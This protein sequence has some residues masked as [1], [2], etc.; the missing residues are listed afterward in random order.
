MGTACKEWACP[1]FGN[2]VIANNDRHRD[3]LVNKRIQRPRK[4]QKHW[5][6]MLEHH[7]VNTGAHLYSV[8][9]SHSA[10][11][12]VSNSPHTLVLCWVPSLCQLIASCKYSRE[13]DLPLND[14]SGYWNVLKKSSRSVGSIWEGCLHCDDGDGETF[15]KKLMAD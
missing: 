9:V 11:K 14:S 10:E 15:G 1:A 8:L 5:I 13:R 7:L 2:F 12:C 6:W 3:S 4:T